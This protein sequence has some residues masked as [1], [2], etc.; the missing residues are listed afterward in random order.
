MFIRINTVYHLQEL[1][2]HLQQ[3]IFTSVPARV[4]RQRDA[5]FGTLVGHDEEIVLD[6]N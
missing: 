2:N 4:L 3:L 5:K 1:N 6:K